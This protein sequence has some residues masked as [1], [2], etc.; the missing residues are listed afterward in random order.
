MEF[1]KGIFMSV[2]TCINAIAVFAL[3]LT[4]ASYAEEGK[5]EE[6]YNSAEAILPLTILFSHANQTIPD[7][8]HRD[9]LIVWKLLPHLKGRETSQGT[10]YRAHPSVYL[11]HELVPDSAKPYKIKDLLA[12][13]LSEMDSGKNTIIGRCVGDKD[14]EC[15]IRITVGFGEEEEAVDIAFKTVKDKKMQDN[16]V[17]DSLLCPQ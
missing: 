7:G 14:K 8:R 13:R 5:K 12:A 11:S 16:L 9:A 10:C 3:F 17:V 6:P 2:K 1:Y 4:G 15:F